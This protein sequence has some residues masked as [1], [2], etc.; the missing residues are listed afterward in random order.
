MTYAEAM[1]TV[2]SKVD[3][4]EIGIASLKPRRAV[5]GG[6]ILEVPGADG[7]AKATALAAKMADALAGT[8]VKVARPI[9]KA[10]LRV[11]GLVDSTTP[12]EVATAVARVGG[13]DQG[14]VRTG[15]IRSSPSGL[16]TIWVQ[17]PAAAARKVAVAGKITV[18]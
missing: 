13:C 10:D 11:R 1:T 3:L 2:R 17:C 4:A 15:G 8:G 5:T 6:I 12:A 14:D 16:G 7:A 9:K 18:G